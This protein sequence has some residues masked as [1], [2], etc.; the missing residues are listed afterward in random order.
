MRFNSSG[1]ALV[2]VPHLQ[3]VDPAN[4]WLATLLGDSG[5]LLLHDL[6]GSRLQHDQTIRELSGRVRAFRW[7]ADG[8]GLVVQT[9]RNV[10][11]VP[12]TFGTGSGAPGVHAAQAVFSESPGRIQDHRILS[13]DDFIVRAANRLFYVRATQPDHVHEL[14]PKNAQVPEANLRSGGRIVMV[15][16][17]SDAK[18]EL[19]TLETSPVT[20]PRIREQRP[21]EGSCNIVNWSPGS[22]HLTYALADGQ[23]VIEVPAPPGGPV[24][25]R[26]VSL[27]PSTERHVKVLWTN[28]SG[29]RVLA[30]SETSLA[31]WNERGEALW[32]WSPSGTRSKIRAAHFEGDGRTIL[33]TLTD[34]VLRLREGQPEAEEVLSTASLGHG[35]RA[36]SFDEVIA[37]PQGQFALTLIRPARRRLANRRRP[38]AGSAERIPLF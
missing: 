35:S 18:D 27:A 9:H 25:T 8:T 2:S 7:L 26:Q 38:K 12:I 1:G 14:T 29:D 37:L 30:A 20:P 3:R 32:N 13:A 17:R 6:S 10:F 28:S 21:C 22:E 11:V 31:V 4:R 23:I 36:V 19:W 5:R 34:R 24:V 15:V 33:L 16:R